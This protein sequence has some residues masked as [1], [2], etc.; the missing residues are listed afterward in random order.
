MQFQSEKIGTLETKKWMNQKFNFTCLQISA[1]DRGLDRRLGQQRASPPWMTSGSSF[2]RFAHNW[3]LSLVF[4]NSYSYIFLSKIE[5]WP[6]ESSQ[7]NLHWLRGGE[8]HF[9]SIPVLISMK[10]NIYQL[11]EMCQRASHHIFVLCS[12]LWLALSWWRYWSTCSD[13][14]CARLKTTQHW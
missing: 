2:C 12:W 8:N 14:C 9:T 13:G 3:H 6:P 10:Y 5:V 11:H 1:F 4:E 7:I